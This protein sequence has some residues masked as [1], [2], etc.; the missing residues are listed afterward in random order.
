MLN[1]VWGDG[2]LCLNGTTLLVFVIENT[3]YLDITILMKS[4]VVTLGY[5]PMENT[6]KKLQNTNLT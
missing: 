3:P 1:M 5:K 6:N 2:L 4:V